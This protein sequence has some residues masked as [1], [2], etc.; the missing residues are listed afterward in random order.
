MRKIAIALLV[1]FSLSGCATK[2]GK[3]MQP[4][5]APAPTPSSTTTTPRSAVIDTAPAAP[6]HLSSTW[7]D[8]EAIDPT[9]TCAGPAHSPEL[10]I[11]DIPAGTS[12]LVLTVLNLSTGEPAWLVA[13][14]SPV[15]GV[16]APGAI[17]AHAVEIGTDGVEPGWQAPCPP[18]GAT[19]EYRLALHALAEQIEMA[20]D[21][22]FAEWEQELAIR[23]IDIALFGGTVASTATDTSAG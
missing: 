9:V 7:A 14:L 23:S 21:A 3:T 6:L 1:G 4:P 12:E 2:D 15:A 22:S 20:E 19:H 11:S 5:T 8:G 16:V 17:P 18:P 13:G 10:V